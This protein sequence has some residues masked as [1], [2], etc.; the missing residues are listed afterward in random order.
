MLATM[1]LSG[2]LLR[3]N[4]TQHKLKSKSM[5]LERDTRGLAS[6]Q[7]LSP[8]EYQFLL[9][10]ASAVSEELIEVSTIIARGGWVLIARGLQ[11]TL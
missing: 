3:E 2:S 6:S 1:N 7:P 8:I 11:L 10:R 9:R 4:K 5:S